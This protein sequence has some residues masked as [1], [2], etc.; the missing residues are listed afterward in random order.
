MC[1]RFGKFIVVEFDETG[2][3]NGAQLKTYLLEKSR[4]TFQAAGERCA[5]P[6]IV[7][8]HLLPLIAGP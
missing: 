3:I 7:N 4:L 5:Y 1:S 6:S 8:S 2:T